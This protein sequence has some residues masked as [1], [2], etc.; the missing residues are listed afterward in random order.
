MIVKDDS[1]GE[2]LLKTEMEIPALCVYV[3]TKEPTYEKVVL[4]EYPETGGKDVDFVEVDPGEG[5][6]KLINQNGSEIEDYPIDVIKTDSFSKTDPNEI[7]L[8]FESYEKLS[9]EDLNSLKENEKS[10]DEFVSTFNELSPIE[11]MLIL[12]RIDSSKRIEEV[13]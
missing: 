11:Q 7:L 13:I 8:I 1:T 4:R 6:W 2:F 5:Y 3:Y 9:E 12:D 10:C